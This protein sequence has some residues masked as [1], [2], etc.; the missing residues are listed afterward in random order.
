[1]IKIAEFMKT[2][3]FLRLCEN[4]KKYWFIHYSTEEYKKRG[5]KT[6]FLFVYS[7]LS[8]FLIKNQVLS[9]IFFN[10]SHSNFSFLEK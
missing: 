4:L 8:F 7:T 6:S 1:M 2:H 9:K 5:L 10:S 3:K